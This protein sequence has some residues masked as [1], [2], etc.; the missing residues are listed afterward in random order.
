M[1]TGL[2]S[3]ARQ[4]TMALSLQHPLRL[5][6]RWVVAWVGLAAEEDRAV[7]V[8]AQGGLMAR[9]DL[10]V[11]AARADHL[12]KTSKRYSLLIRLQSKKTE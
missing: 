9:A 10:E 5:M 7:Q 2:W 11:R 12:R 4:V 6:L 8:E 1:V 3:A